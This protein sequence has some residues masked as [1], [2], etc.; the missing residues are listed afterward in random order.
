[1]IAAST[2]VVLADFCE[3]PVCWRSC[4]PI[5][6]G[7]RCGTHCRR[8]CWREAPR[9]QPPAYAPPIYDPPQVYA[10]AAP[11]YAPAYAR[12]DGPDPSP[13]VVAGAVG[14]LVIM[15][16]A[17]V[18][19]VTAANTGSH[20]FT[21][22]EAATTTAKSLAADAEQRAKAIDRFIEDR[23][24]DARAAGKAAA[25]TEWETKTKRTDQDW[26]KELTRE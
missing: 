15:I 19:A 26:M 21:E 23:A 5:A 14:V 2:T 9:Y 25:E 10:R 6:G 11:D 1:L 7:M 16:F 20:E 18:A 17:I 8:R 24:A 13:A 4:E 3:P 12:T 22:I